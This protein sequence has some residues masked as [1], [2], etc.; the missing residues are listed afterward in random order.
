MTDVKSSPSTLKPPWPRNT[1]AGRWYGLGRYLAMFPPA[2]VQGAVGN[3]TNPGETVLDPFCG[4]GNGPFTAVVMG[5]PAFGIDVNP[6]AWIFTAAKLQPAED[7]EQ[8]ISRLIEVWKAR[9][10]HDSRSQSE[11]DAMAWAPKVRALLRAARRELNWQESKVD[12]TLMAFIA[13]HMQDKQGGGLSNS[14]SPTIAYSPSY[15]VKWWTEQGMLKPPDVDPV[16]VLTDKIRRRYHHGT[17]DQ[18]HGTAVLGDSREVLPKQAHMAAGLLITSPPYC[19]VADYWNDHWL[20]LWLLGHNFRKDWRQSAR[21]ENK[22]DYETLIGSVLQ[23]ASC[24][25]KKGAA[26]LI[27]TDQRRQTAQMCIAAVQETWPDR[28][29]FARSTTAPHKSISVHHGR[30]GR[31]AEEIDLLLPGNRGRSW[32]EQQGFKPIQMINDWSG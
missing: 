15:A 16:Q 10:P 12:R 27:R 5:R 1:A 28:K 32:W 24:H 8:V 4:R 30:G 31:K 11:F 17:P 29:L 25:L 23:E 20:R 13:L 22:S 7:P 3:L 14:M 9:K 26:V 2:F 21:Y 19:G 18:A 6:V